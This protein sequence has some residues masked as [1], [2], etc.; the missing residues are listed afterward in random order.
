MSEDWRLRVDLHEPGHAL[1]LTQHMEATEL[2]HDLKTEFENRVA[3]SRDG[4][5]VF[6]YADTRE[7]AER[8]TELIGELAEKN[9]WKIDSELRRWHPAAEEWEDPDKALPTTDAELATEHEQ[10]LR[11]ERGESEERGYAEFE[12]RMQCSS[13]HD[14]KKLAEKLRGEGLEPVQRWKY[15]LI[16]AADEDDA[17]G[18]AARLREEAPAGCTVTAEGSMREVMDERPFNPFSIFGGLGG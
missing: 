3:V 15:L 13:H 6:C 4:A 11:D 1:E 2:E 14:A 17:Q 7:Q 12:V 5:E 8:V 18:L 10:R 16:A 9:G